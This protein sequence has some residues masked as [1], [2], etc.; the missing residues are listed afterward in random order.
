MQHLHWRNVGGDLFVLID[1]RPPMESDLGSEGGVHI[2]LVGC[3]EEPR[4]WVVFSLW[5]VESRAD[6]HTAIAPV[7]HSGL[8]SNVFF[9]VLFCNKIIK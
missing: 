7:D 8:F 4:G 1:L 2:Q 9:Q 6:V 3:T 5:E